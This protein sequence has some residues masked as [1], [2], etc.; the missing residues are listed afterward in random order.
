ML[1]TLGEA[2]KHWA[3][4]GHQALQD[5]VSGED[6]GAAGAA[7]ERTLASRSRALRTLPKEDAETSQ[8]SPSLLPVSL[9]P[10]ADQG[11]SSWLRK[12]DKSRAQIHFYRAGNEFGTEK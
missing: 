12:I 5:P 10:S 9:V 1:E 4:A 11:C 6:A 2:A 7:V 3:C 8:Q